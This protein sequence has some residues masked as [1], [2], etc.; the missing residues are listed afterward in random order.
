[1]AV[2]S[3]MVVQVEQLYVALFN[4]APDAEGLGYWT[5]RMSAGEDATSIANA[6]YATEPARATYPLY[7][8]NAEIVAAFYENVLGRPGDAEGLGYWEAMMNAPG[9]TPGSVIATMIDVVANYDGED[10][11]GLASSALFANKVAVADYFVRNVGTIEGSQAA[12]QGVTAD[13]D[14]IDDAIA[15]IGGTPESTVDTHLTVRWDNLA[16]TAGNDVFTARIVQDDLGSGKQVNQLGSGDMIDGK[17]GTDILDA[18]LTAGAWAGTLEGSSSMPIHP[19]TTSV[20]IVRLG[21]MEAGIRDWYDDDYEYAYH[22]E[23]LNTDVYVN[24]QNMYGVNEISSYYSD[25]DLSVL[26]MTTLASDGETMRNVSDMTVS[27]RYTGNSDS[28]WGASDMAVLFD[29]DYL[30]PV[31]SSKSTAYYW[32]LDQDADMA[33]LD[34]RLDHI[35]VDG[36]R[37]TIDGGPIISLADPDAQTAGNYEGFVAALQDA[38][39]DLKAAGTVP[40]D[41]TL[42]LDT[43]N[44]R[45][46]YLDNG[47]QSRPV[48]AI[49]LHTDSSVTI[50]P[51][52]YSQV[53]DAL[54]QY[55]VWG[56][57]DNTVEIDQNLSINVVLEKVGRAGDGGELQ[58][59]SMHK[60]SRYFDYEYDTQYPNSWDSDYANA[61]IP[62]FNVTVKG[63]ASKPSSLS[64]LHSTNNVLERIIVTTDAAETG[65]KGYA[66]LTIGNPNTSY[67]GIHDVATVDASAFKGDFSLWADFG[68]GS[69]G[70]KYAGQNDLDYTFGAGNDYLYLDLEQTGSETA[71]YHIAMGEGDDEVYVD[72]DADAV[73]SMTESFSLDLGN[74]DNSAVVWVENN[75]YYGSEYW[76]DGFTKLTTDTL[77]NLSITSGSG[78]DYIEIGGG[79]DD[80]YYYDYGTVANF[81]IKAGGGSDMVFINSGNY[82]TQGAETIWGTDVHAIP[83]VT[84]PNTPAPYKATVMYKGQVQIRYAGFESTAAIDTGT[85]FILTTQ[86]LNNALFKAL[87][88]SPEL[89]RM[90][91]VD[92]AA[93]NQGLDVWAKIDGNNLLEMTVFQPTLIDTGTPTNGQVLVASTDV[94]ALGTALIKANPALDSD[95]VNTAAKIV[96]EFTTHANAKYALGTPAPNAPGVNG[97]TLYVDANL[98]DGTEGYV[99]NSST[100]NMGAGANDLAVLSSYDMS[101]NTLVFDAAWG[102]VSIV[103]FFTDEHDLVNGDVGTNGLHKLD[104]RA[105]L[106]H[107]YSDSGTVQSEKPIAIEAV[108]ALSSA[109]QFKANNIVFTNVDQLEAAA[110]GSPLT[111]YS[112]GSLT[113]G[114]VE[115]ALEAAAGFTYAAA[116]AN[117]VGTVQ[118]SLLFVENTDTA[119]QGVIAGVPGT[120]NYANHGEYKVFQVQYSENAPTGGNP[121]DYTVTLL[122]TLDF[123]NSLDV[124]A[125][126]ANESTNLT[127]G[128]NPGP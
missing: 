50:D 19:E 73:D 57:F 47:A 79:E 49:V 76:D 110:G 38:L 108:D 90:L 128:F 104:F 68:G 44:T 66:A 69:V 2:T 9:A 51:V 85:D 109:G 58:I 126:V 74:G 125:I 17:G 11:D 112:F 26:N 23:D 118:T 8:T 37:F 16:G 106:N 103:N 124:T 12:L 107:K 21:A 5:Q 100:I 97:W 75:Q 72:L 127:G 22:G 83:L 122:G 32:L 24:A 115:T 87:E 4:R 40:A 54:G 91:G 15:A 13:P 67:E 43:T 59:G 121:E 111:N 10:A 42:T 46:T 94:G 113:A 56:R 1:M 89:A 101:D 53:P 78:D 39:A 55:N 81:N 35:N 98:I 63:D 71:K 48:P 80:Y 45:T 86:E 95:D 25:A 62:Q 41:T 29:Q 70:N 92:L 20:E 114:Q 102:K 31:E 60:D 52:G 64:G 3:E 120:D 34:D 119:M 123:G 88:A 33:G 77:K 105:F 7:L 14:S 27:M 18:K 61:G 93:G 82:Q 99:Q 65:T 30:V 36:L 96:T 116:A 117:F 6:M 84:A 28:R